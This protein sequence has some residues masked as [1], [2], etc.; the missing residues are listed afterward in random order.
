MKILDKFFAKALACP[1]CKMPLLIENQNLLCKNSKCKLFNITNLFLSG[2]PVLI[3]FDNS[4][5]LKENFLHSKQTFEIKRNKNIF[6]KIFQGVNPITISNIEL[7]INKINIKDSPKILIIGG[8]EVGSGLNKLY[9]K[10]PDNICAFDIYNSNNIDFIADGHD[11]P[12]VSNYF[13]VIIC[14]AVLEHVLN[15]KLIV[16]EIY[17]VLKDG[18]LVYAETPFMQQVHEG[19][20]DFTRFTE[21]GHR[22]LF[23]NFELV[24]SGYTTGCGTSLIWSLSYF[25][26]GI[27]R[28]KYAGRFCRVIFFWLKY[29]DYIIPY[30]F[31]IDGACGIYFLGKK[32]KNCIKD[33]DI[34]SY[35]NGN[36]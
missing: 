17:R 5:L 27:F 34:I 12:I 10:Y 20:F 4:I 36:Q 35:Y 2:K 32:V 9:K 18:G 33:N 24:N 14:Q 13:D 31:N 11:I 25:F 30:S 16:E 8:G 21:S 29:F 7:I 22:Y 23:K 28:T 3:N 6:K 1:N 15:P 26:T 19:S